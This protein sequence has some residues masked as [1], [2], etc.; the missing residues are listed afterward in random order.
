MVAASP[1]R[2]TLAKSRGMSHMIGV[3]DG[4]GSSSITVGRPA[5]DPMEFMMGWLYLLVAG[6][7]EIAWATGLKASDGLS[8]PLPTALTAVTMVGSVIFLGLALKSP[9][10]REAAARRLSERG[11][12][13]A[14]GVIDLAPHEWTHVA[15]GGARVE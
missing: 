9:S 8:R 4:P 6:L 11:A 2:A 3:G 5:M 10:F 15:R 12:G 7:L 1:A 14:P 13:G